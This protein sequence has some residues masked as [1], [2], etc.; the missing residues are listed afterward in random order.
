MS[1]NE[2][3]VREPESTAIVRF[4]DC[5]P[6]GHLNNIRYLDYFF[7]ARQDHLA[8]F[9]GFNLFE[10]ARQT[11]EGWVVTRT[12]IAYLRPCLVDEVVVIQ[13][14]LLDYTDVTILVEATMLDSRTRRPKAVTWVEFT[15]VSL[16][17]SK[18]TRHPDDLMAFCQSVLVEP[19]Y[20]MDDFPRRLEALKHDNRQSAPV[21][22]TDTVKAQAAPQA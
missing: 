2:T 1:S 3:I 5:D 11:N 18:T 4:Q 15:Y 22:E 9:Y 8:Q 17:T 10:R 13:T 12:Q 19:P 7:N 16:K 14:R 21:S 6:Y 20:R